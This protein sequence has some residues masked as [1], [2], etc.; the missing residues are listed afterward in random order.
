MCDNVWQE[1]ER[2][3]N[4]SVDVHAVVAWSQST[5]VVAFRY[6]LVLPPGTALYCLQV[7]PC[8]AFQILFCSAFRYCLV[9]VVVEVV[10]VAF[11][12]VFSNQPWLLMNAYPLQ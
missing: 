9:A 2:F 10:V 11:V 4:Q 12:A 6:R 8:S 7:L 1:V 5:M 3:V